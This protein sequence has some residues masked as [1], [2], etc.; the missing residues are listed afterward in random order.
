MQ[1]SN[2]RGKKA[3]RLLTEK[4]E[5]HPGHAASSCVALGKSLGL[6]GLLSSAAHEKV[7]LNDQ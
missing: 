5:L 7:G 2:I 3:I 1:E 4:P 6:S